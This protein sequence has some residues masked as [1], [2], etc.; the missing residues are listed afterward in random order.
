MNLKILV[1]DGMFSG[2]GMFLSSTGLNLEL[3]SE[4]IFV[5]KDYEDTTVLYLT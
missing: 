4:L 3:K 5:K 2:D 1:A